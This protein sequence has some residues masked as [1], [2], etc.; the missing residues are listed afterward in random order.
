[1]SVLHKKNLGKNLGLTRLCQK[2]FLVK[3]KNDKKIRFWN[4]KNPVFLT[5]FDKFWATF[6]SNYD[7]EVILLLRSKKRFLS[8][9][10]TPKD[11]FYSFLI[12]FWPSKNLIFCDFSMPNLPYKCDLSWAVHEYFFHETNVQTSTK[13]RSPK[14]FHRVCGG[15]ITDPF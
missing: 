6:C 4:F 7:Y 11:V 15:G 8:V 5:N 14:I 10:Y 13:F 2:I 9:C 1:M 12:I 3:T